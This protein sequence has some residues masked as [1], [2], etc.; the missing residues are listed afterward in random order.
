VFL[1]GSV[2]LGFGIARFFK[3]RARQSSSSRDDAW[4]STSDRQGSPESERGE[5]DEIDSE[6]S[7]DLSA[8][9][10]RRGHE[11][12]S[13]RSRAARGGNAPQSG[14][15]AESNTSQSSGSSQSATAAQQPV[16]RDDD[17]NQSKSRP[18]GK[19]KAKPQSASSGGT[20]QTREGSRP[21]SSER[22][23]TDPAPT[24]ETAISSDTFTGGTGGGALRGGKS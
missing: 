10:T 23:S 4:Q 5:R 12:G 24:D 17:R 1:A 14:T 22:P 20:Q 13:E 18:S 6:E 19:H 16:S 7:L 2:A 15:A 11:G 8:G 9:A 3:A 21:P